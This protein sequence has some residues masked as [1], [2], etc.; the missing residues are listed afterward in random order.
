M[1]SPS[2]RLFPLL[3]MRAL[4]FGES[5]AVAVSAPN[6]RDNEVR[7]LMTARNRGYLPRSEV[8]AAPRR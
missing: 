1:S 8:K 3:Q 6:Y 4:G 5:D 2:L 7:M